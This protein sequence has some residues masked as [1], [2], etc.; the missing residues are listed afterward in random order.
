MG[1]SGD[2]A[3]TGFHRPERV[4]GTTTRLILLLI[5]ILV[6]AAPGAV[7]WSAEAFVPQSPDGWAGGWI[8]S[9]PSFVSLVV[10]LAAVVLLL[11]WVVL[12]VLLLPAGL[13]YVR[14]VESA[15]RRWRG[16]W[17]GA[18]GAGIVLEVLM[19][20]LAYPFMDATPDWGAFAESLGFVAVGTAMIFVLFGAAPARISDRPGIAASQAVKRTP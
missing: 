12:P 5:V 9:V 15:R 6:W 11:S 13:D 20:P 1:R 2:T 3:I 7:V 16:A 4:S 10:E 17:M 8:Y 18:A 19:V 14:S